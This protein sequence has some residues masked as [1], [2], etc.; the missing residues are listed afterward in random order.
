MDLPFVFRRVPHRHV[1]H[2]AD[3]EVVVAWMV[4]TPVAFRMEFV[5]ILIFIALTGVL[6]T[7][8]AIQPD[9]TWRNS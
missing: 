5:L 7:F 9:I 6:A 1:L 3:G 8:N 2:L 4:A